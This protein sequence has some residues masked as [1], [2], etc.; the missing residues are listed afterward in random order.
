M[1]IGLQLSTLS[2]TIRF[3]LLFACPKSNQKGQQAAMTAAACAGWMEL[4]ATVVPG[5][6]AYILFI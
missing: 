3:L 2:K 1:R 6:C 4:S 5:L